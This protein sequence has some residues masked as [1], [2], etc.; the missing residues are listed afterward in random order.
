M[1][2]AA[3]QAPVRE[4]EATPDSAERTL[5]DARRDAQAILTEAER[6]AHAIVAAAERE[7]AQKA[8]EILSAAELA[9]T[10]VEEDAAAALKLAGE[11]RI[12]LATFLRE[13]LAQVQRAPADAGANVR[14]LSEARGRAH[15]A[16][17][18]E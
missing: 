15:R 3:R 16:E 14:S 9:R 12:E 18:A 8:R 11:T 2:P 5:V 13:V 1:Q 17:A 10:R 6:K 7:A 4:R